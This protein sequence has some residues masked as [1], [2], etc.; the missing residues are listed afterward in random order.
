[1]GE[2][3]AAFGERGGWLDPQFFGRFDVNLPFR[4]GLVFKAHRRFVSLNSGLESNKEE[5]EE[6]GSA[7]RHE[8]DSV[9]RRNAPRDPGSR[10]SEEGTT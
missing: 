5:E 9:S 1:M 8:Q 10:A 6:E 4:G 7:T 3:A 2:K